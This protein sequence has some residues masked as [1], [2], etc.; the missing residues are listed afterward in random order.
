MRKK[1]MGKLIFTLVVTC[2]MMQG[3]RCAKLSHAEASYG[4]DSTL[5]EVTYREIVCY[6]TVVTRGILHIDSVVTV[7]LTDTVRRRTVVHGLTAGITSLSGSRVKAAAADTVTAATH[8]KITGRSES[9]VR[10]ENSFPWYWVVVACV[11]AVASAAILR[12]R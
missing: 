5:T 6:D 11:A 4:D 1:A 2:I 7:T 12:A 3:C 10:C 9:T 8:K